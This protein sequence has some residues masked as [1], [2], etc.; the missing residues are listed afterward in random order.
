MLSNIYNTSFSV[1]YI[2]ITTLVIYPNFA[3][4]T[5]IQLRSEIPPS[6]FSVGKLLTRN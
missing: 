4:F 3:T 1:R 5:F 2:Q 6:A